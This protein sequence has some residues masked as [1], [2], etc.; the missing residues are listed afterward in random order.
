VLPY[1]E[2]SLMAWTTYLQLLQGA[3]TLQRQYPDLG[4]QGWLQV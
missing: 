2:L 1:L 4:I 3:L